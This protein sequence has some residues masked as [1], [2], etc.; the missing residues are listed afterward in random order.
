MDPDKF[1]HKEIAVT[2]EM[3]RNQAELLLEIG[4][5]LIRAA[6]MFKFVDG[7]IRDALE[8][9]IRTRLTEAS[10]LIYETRPENPAAA[11]LSH[12]LQIA[13]EGY[14]EKERERLG[15]TKIRDTDVIAMLAFLQR[16]EIDR[17]NGR[18]RGRAFLDFLSHQFG[19]D[20][21]PLPEDDD[22]SRLIIL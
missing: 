20:L 2:Q 3:I 17:N 16:L 4:R 8:A 6:S 13:I 19:A 22:P 14:R 10:G 5:A 11:R 18:P 15:I 12:A 1:P 7:D 21:H 9:V